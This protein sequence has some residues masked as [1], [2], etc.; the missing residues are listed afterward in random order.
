MTFFAFFTFFVEPQYFLVQV[1]HL[2][3][4]KKIRQ[5][6]FSLVSTEPYCSLNFIHRC[7]N[8]I[9]IKL[10]NYL[11]PC[12][13]VVQKTFIRNIWSTKY[14]YFIC[15]NYQFKSNSILRIFHTKIVFQDC[16]FL[17]AWSTFESYIRFLF[18]LDLV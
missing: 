17:A 18:N 11:F 15:F 12:P 14:L 5:I 7:N 4:L 10:M 16:I 6:I 2:R 1:S 9:V 3:M 8:D 13:L